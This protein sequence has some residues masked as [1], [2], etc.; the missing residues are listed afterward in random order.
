MSLNVTLH[1]WLPVPMSQNLSTDR[2]N[3]VCGFTHALRASADI[4]P[5]RWD[6]VGSLHILGA[7]VGA[8]I[9]DTDSITEYAQM[10]EMCMF[11]ACAA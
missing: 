6:A 11:P 10:S 8:M 4:P 9:S 1:T 2:F 7:S 3:Q 5:D